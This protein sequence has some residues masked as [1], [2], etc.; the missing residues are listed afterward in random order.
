M[1]EL[2]DVRKAFGAKTAL[3]SLSIKFE[4][5]EIS[6]L[7]GPSGCGKTTALKLVNRLIEPDAGT[8]LVRGRDAR[9]YDPVKLRRG[10]GYVI[11]EVGLFPHY[12]V[13]D[14]IA[15]VPRLLGWPAARARERVGELLELVT[16]DGSFAA[17]YPGA[18]SGGERQRV[19]L[20]R[21]LAA[22]PDILLMDEPFGAIDA[23]NRATLQNVLLG[24]QKRL[25]KTIVIVT[26]DIDE[27]LKLADRIAILK[28]GRLL[29]FD[30]PAGLLALPG[31][32]F[33]AELL[34]PGRT[35]G[36]AP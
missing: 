15:L 31:D 1:I 28:D 35:A 2:A 25:R 26:H 13:A 23:I 29:R 36:T 32:P 7:I 4:T 34:G 12:T 30:S 17:R 22:D 10:I 5:G 8:V 14:N 16:L 27:A 33:V 20:A 19:G 21:A 6:A 9:T 24:I 11:Q 3:A 18:L